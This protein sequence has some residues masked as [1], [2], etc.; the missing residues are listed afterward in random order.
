VFLKLLSS[1]ISQRLIGELAIVLLAVIE[2]VGLE[3]GVGVDVG[4]G[5][6]V[7]D[8]DGDGEEVGAPKV[9]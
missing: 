6:G 7:E 5:V 9:F 1:F 3:V 8:G 2:G 4:V